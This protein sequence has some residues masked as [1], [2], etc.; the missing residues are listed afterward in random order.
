MKY[1]N[2]IKTADELKNKYRELCL[3]LHPDRGGKEEDF[4]MMVAEYEQLKNQFINNFA[5]LGDAET[6]M[7][8]IGQSLV[9]SEKYGY[10]LPFEFIS[11]FI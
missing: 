2:N 1:F 9:G 10:V 8:V 7:A 3:T 11:I 4:K 5:K 6:P